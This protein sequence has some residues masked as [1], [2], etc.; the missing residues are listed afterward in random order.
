MKTD[1]PRVLLIIGC[2]GLVV[3]STGEVLRSDL[4][5]GVGAGLIV[6]AIAGLATIGW[7][8]K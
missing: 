7:F 1:R 2:M 3:C 4:L 6:G 8:D 5:F